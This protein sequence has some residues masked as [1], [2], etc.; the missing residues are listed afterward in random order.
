MQ[1]LHPQIGATMCVAVLV[2]PHLTPQPGLGLGAFVSDDS[3]T[4]M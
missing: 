1:A 2:L 3:L 4:A